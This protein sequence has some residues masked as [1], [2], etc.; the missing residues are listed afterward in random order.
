M[1]LYENNLKSKAP[2][3]PFEEEIIKLLFCRSLEKKYPE[4]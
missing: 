4:V 1:L 2:F 3:F